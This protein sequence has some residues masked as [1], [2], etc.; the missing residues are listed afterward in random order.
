[1]SLFHSNASSGPLD[2]RFQDV[3]LQVNDHIIV[4]IWVINT[5]FVQFLCVSLPPLFSSLLLSFSPYGFCPYHIHSCMKC[6]CDISNFLE[7]TTSLS[8][9]IVFSTFCTVDLRR[10]SYLSLLFSG[11]LHSG[12]S[13]PFSLAFCFSSFLSFV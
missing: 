13:F 7:G 12:I 4:V 8:H 11:T 5:F 6:P 2:F 10:P 1:M 9:S 3:R